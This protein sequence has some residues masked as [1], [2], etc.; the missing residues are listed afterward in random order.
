MAEG[1]VIE[2]LRKCSA[3]YDEVDDFLDWSIYGKI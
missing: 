3:T 1:E 2:Y